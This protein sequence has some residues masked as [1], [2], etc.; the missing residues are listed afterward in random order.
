MTFTLSEV[1]SRPV[2]VDIVTTDG[3]ASFDSGDYYETQGRIVFQPG[4]TS[5]TLQIK[6]NGDTVAEG[7]EVFYVDLSNPINASIGDG[8]AVITIDDDDV[9]SPSRTTLVAVLRPGRLVARGTVAPPHPG[10]SMRVILKKRRNG[11]FRT[12]AVRRP[13][14]SEAVDRDGDGTFESR[15]RTRFSRPR[16]GRC[17]L[18]A[19]FPGD[20]DHARSVARGTFRC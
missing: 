18:R 12:I 8:R 5:Q 19:V 1:S 15:Y 7:D 3:S 20:E 13:L 6:V 14:L 17:S 10:E 9:P 2:S 16:G 4:E 11:R